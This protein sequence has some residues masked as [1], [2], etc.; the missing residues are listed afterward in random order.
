MQNNYNRTIHAM[1]L[2]DQKADI[3][4]KTDEYHMGS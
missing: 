3:Y 1:F 4:Y 2:K